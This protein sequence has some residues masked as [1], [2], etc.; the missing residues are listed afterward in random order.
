ME[1]RSVSSFE[2]YADHI[3]PDDV[4][5]REK[6]TVL[7]ARNGYECAQV[8]VFAKQALSYDVKVSNLIGD[9]GAVY[10][11]SNVTVYAEKYIYVDRNWQ[12]NGLPTGNYPDALLPLE[13]AKEYDETR[14]EPGK[15]KGVWLEFFVPADQTPG[16]YRGT[17]TVEGDGAA[18]LPVELEVLALDIP[19]HTG[20]RT[21]FHTNYEHMCRYEK[22]DMAQMHERYIHYLLKH[23]ICQTEFAHVG[24][25][26]EGIA[27]FA[28]KAA[29][30]NALGFNTF[31]IPSVEEKMD[32]YSSFSGE[33][34]EK[35]LFA[36]AKK[37]LECGKDLVKLVAFYDWRIDEPFFVPYQPGRVQDSVERFAQS[38]KR[39]SEKCAALPEFGSDFGRQ[40]V[41]SVKNACHVITDYYEKPYCTPKGKLTRD[42]QPYQYDCEKV[43]LC[44]KFDGYDSP[45]LAAPYENCQERWWYGCNTPNA[46]FVSYHIDDAVFSPRIIGDMMA[47]YGIV[48]NLYWANN[49]YTEINTTGSPLF[50]DDPY[51]TAHRGSGANGE[52]AIL[53]PGSIYG[54]DG[55]VGC[56]R[57][58]QIRE[59]NQD[60]DIWMQVQKH[61]IQQGASFWDVFDRQLSYLSQGTKIDSMDGDYGMV[62]RC[63]MYLAEAAL[64]P[65]GLILQCQRSHNGVTYTLHTKKQCQV[66][67]NGNPL[68]KENGKYSFYESYEAGKWSDL[69]ICSSEKCW[70]IPIYKGKGMQIILHEVLFENNA[71]TADQGTVTLNPDDVRREITVTLE[72]P[73][74]IHIHLD[75]PVKSGEMLGFEIKTVEPCYCTVWADGYEKH[76]IKTIPRWNRIQIPTDAPDFQTNGIHICMEN[77]GKVGIGAVYIRR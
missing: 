43:T 49:I 51:Q 69:T 54:V 4:A 18:Q 72:N 36:L 48:G 75:E 60:W 12:T 68:R 77:A 57:L 7:A 58:K 39:A 70:N 9:E 59:G 33:Y 40:L 19:D 74:N 1:L 37:S 31:S 67:L 55:P 44:P 52:G 38:A 35:Y 17:V 14:I 5:K 13:A 53:Y 28:E 62:H 66:S 24:S 23:R 21:L 30:L 46:P 15:N 56:I 61:Y 41:K 42:G 8:L 25:T 50:L 34:I 47:R 27:K 16:V 29:Q 20:V 63:L 6:V 10:A 76:R 11:A 3:G 71:V 26:D 22:G 2:K 65:L 32:G 45:E 73:G 64:S